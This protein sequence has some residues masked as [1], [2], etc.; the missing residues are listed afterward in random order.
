MKNT[1]KH[2]NKA[3]QDGLALKFL[4]QLTSLDFIGKKA[5]LLIGAQRRVKTFLGGFLSFLIFALIVIGFLYFGQEIVFKQIPSVVLSSVIND[6]SKPILIDKENFNFLFTLRD[7]NSGNYLDLNSDF[8]DVKVSKV[9]WTKKNSKIGNEKANEQIAIQKINLDL[10]ECDKIYVSSDDNNNNNDNNN[11]IINDSEKNGGD[12]NESAHNY[13][14]T[15]VFE[16]LVNNLNKR[17]YKCLAQNAQISGSAETTQLSYLEIS[18]NSCLDFFEFLADATGQEIKL[19]A[20]KVFK[21]QADILT[22]NNSN[23]NNN[24]ENNSSNSNPIKFNIEQLKKIF[25]IKTDFSTSSSSTSNFAEVLN[26]R[27]IC[28]FT[29]LSGNT[30][31][32]S[33]AVLNKTSLYGKNK[34]LY[35]NAF[36]VLKYIE[37]YFDVRSFSNLAN[38]VI[39]EYKAKLNQNQFKTADAN[40]KQIEYFTDKGLILED[41]EITS[42]TQLTK[43]SERFEN[44]FYAGATEKNHLDALLSFRFNS[45]KIREVFFRK[46][47]KAQNLI[48]ELGGLLKSFFT[49][50]LILNYFNNHAKYYEKMIDDLFDVDDLY[51]Y[52][53]YYNS[54]NKT[55]FRK[56]RD[57]ILLRNTKSMDNFKKNIVDK[58]AQTSNQ[59]MK[60]RINQSKDLLEGSLGNLEM[61]LFFLFIFFNFFL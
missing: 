20:E 36:F 11:V 19:V 59:F 45:D 48:A 54:K 25:E 2:Q 27:K 5:E 49:V 35:F 21:N 55:I 34:T 14:K 57:S 7:S 29:N 6:G 30:T 61:V 56:Y 40:L 32:K 51:K 33:A 17:N 31:E 26:T 38:Y 60:T 39:E 24:N 16:S 9:I 42:Y 8:L 52:Y 58:H 53:Q 1:S 50:A 23:N 28:P 12:V 15:F 4:Q 3:N 44:S 47:Y 37:T 10:I 41:F 43:I 22:V 13:N 18:V 46:Y